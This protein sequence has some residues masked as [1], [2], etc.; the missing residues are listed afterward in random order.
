MDI[1]IYTTSET[2]EHK[3]GADGYEEY[4]W[5]LS[6]PPI[7]FKVGDRIFFAINKQI[8]GSFECNDFNPVDEETLCWN[9][10][11][12]KDIEPIPCKP[13]QGFK[14]KK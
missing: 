1:I 12:W 6:N 14:Y 4:Y 2:L 10:N 3:K 13:F 9:K 7:K 11:T 8:V 5:H